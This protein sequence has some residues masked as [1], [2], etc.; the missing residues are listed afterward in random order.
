M[1]KFAVIFG[2]TRLPKAGIFSGLNHLINDSVDGSGFSEYFGFTESEV[3]WLIS[4]LIK[5]KPQLSEE[6]V[7]KSVKKLYDGYRVESKTIY[8]PWSIMNCLRALNENMDNPYRYYWSDSESIKIIEDA[9]IQIPSIEMIEWLI[10]LGQVEFYYDNAF[11]FS[12]IKTNV[13]DLLS[14]LLNAGYITKLKESIY[15]TPNQEVNF[16]IFKN[17]FLSGLKSIN[18]NQT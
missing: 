4:K 3:D 18:L 7:K 5:L 14:L 12:S 1:V 11:T 16:Y 2:A 13:R 17:S 9:I 10:M 8:N 15:K 6:T